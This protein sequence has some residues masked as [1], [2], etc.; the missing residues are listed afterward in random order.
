MHPLYARYKSEK[1]IINVEVKKNKGLSF[2]NSLL[3][4]FRVNFFKKN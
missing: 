2:M 1:D 3:S 4:V